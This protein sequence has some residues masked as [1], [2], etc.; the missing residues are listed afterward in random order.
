MSILNLGIEQPHLGVVGAG[1]W[2]RALARLVDVVY[3][4]A[5]GSVAGIAAAI[6]LLFLQALSIADPGWARRMSHPYLILI[7]IPAG[8]VGNLSYHTLCEGI[9]GAS[10]G[11]L[12]CGL[13]VLSEDQTPCR[14]GPAFIRS[15]AYLVDGLVFGLVGYLSMNKTPLS[16]RHGDHWAKT[17]VVRRAQVPAESKRSGYVFVSAVTFGSLA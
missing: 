1:F 3:G 8:F 15:I 6:V 12:V 7:L 10:V 17:I 16:Q 11:K 2:I 5:V 13:R 14:L 4:Y 9:Y